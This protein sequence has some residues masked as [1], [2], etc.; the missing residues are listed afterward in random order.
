[1]VEHQVVEVE[2]AHASMTDAEGYATPEQASCADNPPR[3]VKQQDW[4]RGR[5][6][7]YGEVCPP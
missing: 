7:D 5:M 2:R 4:L 3:S 6:G 1:V